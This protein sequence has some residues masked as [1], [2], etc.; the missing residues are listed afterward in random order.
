MGTGSR[1]INGETGEIIML[2][3][4]YIHIYIYIYIYT[5]IGRE[6]RDPPVFSRDSMDS[7]GKD[8]RERDTRVSN[9]HR[10]LRNGMH[11]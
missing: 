10:A 7:S 9:T 11:A 8:E 6:Y 1:R 5:Y 4:I 3:Y 2:C